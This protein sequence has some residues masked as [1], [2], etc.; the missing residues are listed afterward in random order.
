MP[1][2]PFYEVSA[3]KYSKKYFYDALGRVE[4]VCETMPTNQR[5]DNKTVWRIIKK[6]YDGVSD[7]VLTERWADGSNKMKFNPTLRTTYTY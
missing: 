3:D 5:N 1:P 7:R 4:Y 6:T 2:H